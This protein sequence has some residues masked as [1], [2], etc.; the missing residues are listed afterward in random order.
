MDAGSKASRTAVLVA[1]GRAVAD[2]RLAVG[3]FSDPIAYALLSAGEQAVVDQVRAGAQPADF[4]NRLQ[5]DLVRATAEV[6]AAR[7]IAIDDAVRAAGQSQLVIL[8]AGLDSRAW[9]MPELAHTVVFAV[10]HPATQADVRQRLGQRPSVAAEVRYVPIDFR[11]ERAGRLGPALTAAD[12]Q[13]AVPTTWVSEGVV[14]YL[15]PAEVRATVEEIASLSAVGSRLVINY[16][17]RSATAAAGRLVVRGLSRLSGRASPLAGE[18]T[19]STWTPDGLARLLRSHRLIVR[20]DE[21]LATVAQRVGLVA[22][23]NQPLRNGRVAIAE[24]A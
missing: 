17:A 4:G 21:D 6:L 15:S 9:R 5:F 10:D 3:R 16:Q 24:L 2:G 18:P 20:S 1:Q 23:A 8:G 12:H 19:R 14:P 7:T 11:A 13:S 22:K